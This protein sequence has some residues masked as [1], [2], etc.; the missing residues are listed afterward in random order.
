M[1]YEYLKAVTA[2]FE[3]TQ[4]PD[5]YQ[6]LIKL[7]EKI[8]EY[9]INGTISKE[10][11]ISIFGTPQ[12]YVENT[13]HELETKAEEQT[14]SILT[15]DERILQSEIK[16]ENSANPKAHRILKII[17]AIIGAIYSIYSFIFLAV[18]IIIAMAVFVLVDSNTG[19][20]LLVGI[21][22]LL[23]ALYCLIVFVK[24]ILYSVV[25]GRMHYIKLI[26]ATIFLIICSIV[27]TNALSS[28]FSSISTY[29]TED[30]EDFNTTISSY[31]LDQLDIDWQNFSIGD[32][33]TVSTKIRN[34][35]IADFTGNTT[36]ESSET[37]SESESA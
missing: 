21:L 16:A 28:S 9:E 15:D 2:I 34:E 5:R 6:E 11:L 30:S 26:S 8:T 29:S 3:E 7:E 27:S 18:T 37:K 31:G 25:D 32:Y 10:Q 12:E 4:F 22:L 13:I 24:N 36:D 20:Y 23:T 1:K 35:L 14:N 17:F 33:T 19:I